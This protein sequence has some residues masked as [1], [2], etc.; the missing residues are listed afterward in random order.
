MA[1]QSRPQGKNHCLIRSAVHREKGVF[2][3]QALRSAKNKAKNVAM[4]KAQGDPYAGMPI[5]CEEHHRGRL[6]GKWKW[7]DVPTE[8]KV[9]D[10]ETKD[11]MITKII[12][13]PLWRRVPGT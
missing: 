5:K 8:I 2:L 12:P 1:E 11:R 9:L 13:L 6:H 3:K 10:K 7:V 4:N